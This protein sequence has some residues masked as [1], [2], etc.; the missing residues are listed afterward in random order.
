M[1]GLIR[2]QLQCPILQVALIEAATSWAREQ[3]TLY[4]IETSKLNLLFPIHGQRTKRETSFKA[5]QSYLPYSVIAPGFPEPT[6]V[7]GRKL[8]TLSL[9]IKGAQNITPKYKITLRKNKTADYKLCDGNTE[10]KNRHNIYLIKCT[11]RV[12]ILYSTCTIFK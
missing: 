3:F 6:N 9:R 4:S 2:S 8:S 1:Q 7:I 12:Y 10:D 5:N 11:R